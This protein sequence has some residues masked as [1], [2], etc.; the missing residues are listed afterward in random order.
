MKCESQSLKG[1]K[2]GYQNEIVVLYFV[3]QIKSLF[4]FCSMQAHAVASRTPLGQ[5][6]AVLA[7]AARS[8]LTPKHMVP[9]PPPLARPTK[10]SHRSSQVIGGGRRTAHSVNPVRGALSHV[11]VLDLS[12]VL[13]GT[14]QCRGGLCAFVIYIFLPTGPWATQT[15]ADLGADVIKVERPQQGDDTR[16]WGPP[17]IKARTRAHM[18]THPVDDAVAEPRRRECEWSGPHTTGQGGQQH[19][20]IGLLPV[21]QPRQTGHHVRHH[22]T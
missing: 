11:R 17:F 5:T 8:C 15:L 7:P 21:G 22:A 20:A 2:G 19:Q 18:H 9:T 10:P 3:P 1:L 16:G 13:A 14:Y 6:H 4:P 12:R